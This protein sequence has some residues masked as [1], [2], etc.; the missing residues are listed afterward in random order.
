M[1]L[2]WVTLAAAIITSMVGQV[3]L[4]AGANHSVNAAAGFLDQL[5]AGRRS[6]ALGPMAALRCSTSSRC[7]ASR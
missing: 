7:G 5:F 4:K 2:A 6:S 3:L 1:G